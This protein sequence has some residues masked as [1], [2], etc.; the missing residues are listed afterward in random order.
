MANRSMTIVDLKVYFDTTLYTTD[1]TFALGEKKILNILALLLL[2]PAGSRPKSILNLRLGKIE[3][4]LRKD[5]R[6]PFHGPKRLRIRKRLKFTK[7]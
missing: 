1:K 5:Y 6:N 2:S 3:I 4:V 7:R